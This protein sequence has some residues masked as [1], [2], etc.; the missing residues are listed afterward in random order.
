M[1]ERTRG[2]LVESNDVDGRDFRGQVHDA[3]DLGVVL[4]APGDVFDPVAN[5]KVVTFQGGCFERDFVFAARCFA[6]NRPGGEAG[7]RA[8]GKGDGAYAGGG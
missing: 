6:F 5:G 4:F 3:Y 7:E 1:T 8:G 2:L